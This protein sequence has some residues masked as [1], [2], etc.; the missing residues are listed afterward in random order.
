[1]RFARTAVIAI[2]LVVLAPASEAQWQSFLKSLDRKIWKRIEVTG[3]RRLSYHNENITGDGEAYTQLQYA[4][5]NARKFTDIGQ[6]QLVGRNVLDLFNFRAQILDYR[7]SDPQ[8]QHFSLDVNKK[9]WSV[10]A[11]DIQG[12][13]LN[14]NRF[15]G[16]AKTLKG[17]QAQY[18]SGRFA[19]KAVHSQAKGSA[20]TISIQGNNSAGPYYL[21]NSQIIDGS[22]RVL[23]DGSEMARGSDYSV[24]NE[25]GSITFVNRIIPLTSTIVVT[26]EA[27]GFNERRGVIQGASTT[28]DFGKVG[29]IGLTAMR[30]KERR[31]SNN[32][33]VIEK[34]QGF[35]P[36]TTPYF[37]E[38][39]PL[40]TLPI[41]IRLNG[42]IQT[43]GVDYVFDTQNSAV[44][45]F[46]RFVPATSTIDVTYTPKPR[47]TASG[48]R[49][50]LGI[51]YQIPLGKEGKN[52]AV[53][54]YQA[55][56]KLT[57]SLTPLRG[58][59]RGA[60]LTYRAGKVNM[61]AS[62]RSVPDTFVTIETRGFNRNERA[63]DWLLG[64]EPNRETKLSLDQQN[65]AIR[66]RATSSTGTIVTQSS[67]FT[68]IR[69]AAER[70]A[71]GNDNWIFSHVRTKSRSTVGGSRT[72]STSL[73][74][75]QTLGRMDFK[76]GFDRIDAVGPIGG[77]GQVGSARLL[78]GRV[79]TAY[80]A[81]SELSF[82]ANASVTRARS[83][84]GG[85]TGK[86]Y[87]I[88]ATY[89]PSEAWTISGSHSL[90]DSGA[91]ATLGSFQN[92]YGL[93]FDGNGFSGGPGGTGI[94]G[95]TNSRLSMLTASYTPSEKVRLDARLFNTKFAGSVSSN[96]ESTS[97]G[98]SA[99]FDLGRIG[100][101]NANI[102]RS[103]TTFVGSPQSSTTDTIG[104]Y[105]DG[106]QGRLG[107]TLGA[108]WLLGGGNNTTNQDSF[109]YQLSLNYRLKRRHIL[110]F[111]A[112]LGRTQGYL[113]Q[114]S[115]D[116]TAAYR[117]TIWNNVALNA[118]YRFSDVKNIGGLINSGAYRT[119]GFHVELA[120]DFGN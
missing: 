118:Y 27:F 106:S 95:A 85:G 43:L 11:G 13:L 98:L 101:L 83:S 86:D 16:F 17:V 34:F 103:R 31:G 54:L 10:N 94:T 114:S 105:F 102:D 22:V 77:T 26:F 18:R 74:S 82:S 30:Q 3:Y 71:G 84:S 41:V 81:S 23:V 93:G 36:P 61:T 91:L 6:M 63:H 15:A 72:D 4:S 120:L 104:V 37:L 117:Y 19:A 1:M 58:T 14:T 110:S 9:G 70:Q 111:N 107:Y 21:Q 76:L 7:F 115:T 50:T 49:E 68:R 44:F 56:G 99:G 32:A 69:F 42:V 8:G 90:S 112:L 24:N 87:G 62:L 57:N 33:A 48:D 25:I 45:Y 38:F 35:G 100:Q 78:S 66:N 79:S 88:A 97:Y 119:R 46:L 2:G 116:L 109:D 80:Q 29:R 60:G 12:S 5:A 47:G 52:G 39:E 73:D 67:R 65:S 75:T 20:R 53:N 51:D 89:Q 59:A 28:Y 92:G 40:A 64:Y 55:T 113:P 108:S 96:T